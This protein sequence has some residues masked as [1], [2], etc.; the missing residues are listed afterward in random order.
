MKKTAAAALTVLC[1]SLNVAAD[2]RKLYLEKCEEA[3]LSFSHKIKSLEYA[4]KSAQSAADSQK[5]F[6][7]P[8]IVLEG[9][10]KY[11]SEV[12]QLNN[13]KLGDNW[14]YSIGPAIYWAAFDGNV[15]NKNYLSFA[16]LAQAKKHELDY[17]KRE[18]V[19]SVRIAYFKLVSSLKTLNLLKRQLSLA[20]SQNNDVQNSVRAG[21]AA[22]LDMVISGTEVL[23]KRKQINEIQLLIT[24]NIKELNDLT[25]GIILFDFKDF[26]YADNRKKLSAYEEPKDLLDKF[27][28]YKNAEFDEKNPS[29]LSLET[30]SR[31]YEILAESAINSNYPVI[32]LFAKTSMDYPNGPAAE[33]YN[34][35]AAG[36]SF[37]VPVYQ[38]GRNKKAFL[39]RK[40]AGLSYEEKKLELIEELGRLFEYSKYTVKILEAQKELNAEIERQTKEAAELMYK[41]YKAGESKFLDV[42]TMNLRVAESQTNEVNTYADLLIQLAV[43][44]FLAQ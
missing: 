13:I 37:S 42:E 1:F 3:A 39:D 34:Q 8:S 26:D 30:L 6:N 40:Y 21:A 18:T 35:N 2:A 5:T 25:G 33:S 4:F 32:N 15:R 23:K 41:S 38:F 29:I 11:M 36:V 20:V 24:D 22:K 12:P 14:N 31:Y 43:L 44:A 17:Q 9:N 7:Y 28:A 19:L 27:S 10:L 16:K